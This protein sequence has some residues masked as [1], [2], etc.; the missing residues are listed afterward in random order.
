MNQIH[1]D[2]KFNPPYEDMKTMNK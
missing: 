1:K 2:I